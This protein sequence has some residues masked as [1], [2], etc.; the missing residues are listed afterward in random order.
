MKILYVCET[1]NAQHGGR[2]HAREFF[3]ALKN[4]E[5]VD[6][7]ESFYTLEDHESQSQEL[8]EKKASLKLPR[9]IYNFLKM[10]IMHPNRTMH[11]SKTIA[12]IGCDALIVRNEVIRVNYQEIKSRF[13][14]LKIGIEFN[15]VL[16][17]ELFVNRLLRWLPRYLEFRQLHHVDK[18]FPVS[19][20]LRESMELFG[21]PSEKVIVNPNGVDVSRFDPRLLSRK[22]I[23]RERYGI[24]DSTFVIGYVGGMEKFRYLPDLVEAFAILLDKVNLGNVFLFMVGDGEQAPQVKSKL[25]ALCDEKNYLQLGWQSHEDV[26]NIMATF[27]LAVMPYTQDYCS[28]LKLFEYMAMGLPTLGPDTDSVRELFEDGEHLWLVDQSPENHQQL[29]NQI[30]ALMKDQDNMAAVAKQGSDYVRQHFT[31]EAN[32]KRVVDALK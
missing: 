23:L 26:P 6:Q 27:D 31:W 4:S 9:F 30:H 7:V 10:T 13:P 5:E 8:I 18:V 32:A 19:S 15:A 22:Q 29:A 1:I 2:T 12:E 20:L 25:L 21:V 3:S 28:P 24:P 11:I 16:S 14:D 17:E